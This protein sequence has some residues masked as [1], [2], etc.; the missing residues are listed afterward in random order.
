MIRLLPLLRAS[1]LLLLLPAIASAQSPPSDTLLIDFG[2]VISPAP[3]NNIADPVAA[4]IDDLTNAAGFASGYGLRI[5]DPFN[6]INT[7]GTQAPDPAIGFPATATGDSFF[8]SITEFGGQTQPSGGLELTRLRPEKTYT[9]QIFASRTATD[10][11]EAQ[12]VIEGAT[13]DTVYLDAAS[14]TSMVATVVM[15][16]GMDSLIRITASPGPN[17]TNSAGF[18]YLGAIKVVYDY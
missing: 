1:L 2:N 7:A 13:T 3:W 9:F 17:N 11:R 18:Y 12:Y 4:Q 5:F 15:Q 16:P 8:G 14:N 6:N 10:N